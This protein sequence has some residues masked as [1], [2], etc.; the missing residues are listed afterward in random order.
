MKYPFIDPVLIDLGLV[1]IYWYGAMYLFAMVVFYLL[2][3]LRAKSDA[4]INTPGKVTDML[5]GGMIG[6]IVGGRVGFFVFYGSDAFF[7]DPLSIFRIWEGGMSFH[8]GL[9]GVL[10]ATYIWARSQKLGYLQV[11]D[12]VAP[13]VPI[14]LGLGRIANFINTELPGRITDI[15]LGV[16]FPCHAIRPYNPLCIGEYEEATRHLSSVY[17]AF[18]EGVVL[19]LVVWLFASRKREIGQISGVFLITAGILRATTEM[20]RSPDPDLGYILFDTLTM[21][22]LLSIPVILGGIVLLLP[23]TRNRLGLR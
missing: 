19:F 18:A 9:I 13:L 12:F 3:R 14:G 21:G 16:H 22:Q 20:F 8:G 23:Q 11:T 1:T 4:V 7:A 2:G 17:Q 6:V 15:S 5:F 10:T